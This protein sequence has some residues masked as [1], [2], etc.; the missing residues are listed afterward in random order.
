MAEHCYKILNTTISC[1]SAVLAMSFC[2]AVAQGQ[3]YDKESMTWMSSPV[4]LVT[5]WTQA[6][7]CCLFYQTSERAMRNA[8]SAL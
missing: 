2:V 4:S 3:Y 1:K 5:Y 8:S 6:D 7:L